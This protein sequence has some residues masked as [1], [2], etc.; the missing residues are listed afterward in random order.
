[1]CDLFGLSCNAKDR[2]TRSLPLFREYARFNRDG[3]GIAYYEDNRAIVE[4]KPEAAVNSDEFNRV[5]D[6]AR[7][8]NI[9]S[10]L[11]LATSGTSGNVNLCEQNC[12]PF[13]VNYRN[14]DWVFAH[15]GVVSSVNLTQH[16][17]SEGNTDSENVFRYIIDCIRN[18]QSEGRIRGFY[19]AL[20]NA[21]KQ[22]FNDF[23]E[24]ID[25]NFLMSDGSMYYAFSHHHR[26]SMY[27]LK[28]EKEYGG[29]ILLSTRR[30]TDENW[31]TIPKDRLMVINRGEIVVL[32]DSILN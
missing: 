17:E 21:L 26:K 8:N 15:N 29:A 1:M 11:R 31:Q 3:W 30:L 25:L 24:D 14:R 22:V 19:A 28:R 4:G 23:G 10:H 5:I 2:A 20:V 27:F 13:K 18:Y 9:I 6:E 16:P 12:H 7:S 32:S